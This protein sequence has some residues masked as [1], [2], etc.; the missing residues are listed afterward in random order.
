MAVCP[1]NFRFEVAF[2]FAGPH[3]EKVRAIAERVSAALDPEAQGDRSRG[4]VFFDE[5]FEHEILGSDMDVL[6]QR[7]YHE[8]SLMV[9]ADV[10]EHYADREWTQAEA[11]AIRALRMN[12]D[13]ARDETAR[14]RLLNIRFGEGNVPGIF[15]TEGVPDARDKSVEECAELILK[16]LGLLKERRC[17]GHRGASREKP[18][19]AVQPGFAET[20]K[21]RSWVWHATLASRAAGKFSVLACVETL[22]AVM[23][24]WW[25]ALRFDTHWHLVS[26]V[27]IAPLLLL[28]SPVAIAAGVRWFL[29]DWFGFGSY[30]KWPRGRKVVWIAGFALLS[31]IPAWG[32]AQGLGGRWLTG[33]PGLEFL[34]WS[35][36]KGVVAVVVGLTIAVAVVG[37]TAISATVRGALLPAVVG[38]VAA[39]GAVLG[40]SEVIGVGAFVGVFLGATAAVGRS[41]GGSILRVVLLAIFIALAAVPLGFAFGIGIA[42]RSLCTRLGATIAHLL[43]GFRSLPANWKENNFLTDSFVPAELLPGIREHNDRLTFDGWVRAFSGE[44]DKVLRLSV[45]PFTA[46]F[47]LPSFL[48]RLNIKATAWFWWPLAYLLQPAPAVSAEAQEKQALCWPWTNPFSRWWIFT[49]VLLVGFGFV[50]HWVD[51]AA[52]P[53]WA[54]VRS[55]PLPLRVLLGLEWAGLRPWH[56]AQWGIAACGLGM[57]ALA[58]NARSHEAHGNW[59]AFRQHCS[60]H[61]RLM[62]GLRRLRNL[63]TWALLVMALGA[64]LLQDRKWQ[65]W[66]P[67]PQGWITT[68][69]GFYTPPAP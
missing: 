10:S 36:A 56:W 33:S 60:G 55:L 58:G 27:F 30:E 38:A 44:K 22:L 20:S 64:L 46:A 19:D 45:V 12:L 16:R 25:I 59:R 15:N 7:F 47:F 1:E 11:R 3:R 28:R 42:L 52:W 31:A 67:V 51:P 65:E 54:P 29:K 13:P 43:A 17:G 2:S 26:S 57:L 66:V 37:S 4:R 39:S 53:A 35:V 40:L 21:D 61:V 6:L 34:G 5:W 14:L 9:V 18:L 68:L 48:Y 8:Q 50:V 63:S 49:S 32:V 62:T 23:L 69:E 41:D 24:Y